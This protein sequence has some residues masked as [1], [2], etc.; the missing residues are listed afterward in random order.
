MLNGKEIK[1]LIKRKKLIKGFIDLDVQLTPNGFDLTAGNIFEF[2]GSGALDFSNSERVIPAEKE[3][4]LK[5][6]SPKDKYGW[7]NLKSGAYK[8]KTN[9][10]FNLPRDLMAFAFSRSSLLR[11]GLFV[12]TGVWDAGF[13]GKAEFL[14]VVGN[15]KG[16]QIKQNA[17]IT[18]LIFQKINKAEKGYSGIYKDLK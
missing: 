1:Y 18:Q 2:V 4:K 14:L 7:W 11:M 3:V 17:R 9:E 12:Q 10:T 15:S 5:K 16:A 13:Q 6:K 8:I